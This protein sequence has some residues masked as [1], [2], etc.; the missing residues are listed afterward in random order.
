MESE[1]E[2]LQRRAGEERQAAANASS[3]AARKAHEE[4]AEEYRRRS[5]A[6]ADPGA[7]RSS[8]A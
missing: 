8:T 3:E 1:R 5:D 4:L 2:F 7:S 6:P